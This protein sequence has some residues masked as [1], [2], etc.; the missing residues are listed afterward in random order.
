MELAH[1]IP[2]LLLN[3]TSTLD[4][5][6]QCRL[7]LW[8]FMQHV[9]IQ[10]WA[11]RMLDSSTKVPDGVLYGNLY[12]LGNFDECVGV[13]SSQATDGVRFQ[14]QYCSLALEGTSVHELAK[15]LEYLIFFNLDI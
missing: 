7:H 14:G 1:I 4:V 12:H 13:V 3:L 9:R 11:A 5:G 15:R 2:A 6:P 8:H 10:E